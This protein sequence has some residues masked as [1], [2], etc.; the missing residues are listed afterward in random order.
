LL[1]LHPVLSRHHAASPDSTAVRRTRAV[2]LRASGAG[3][4]PRWGRSARF[5]PPGT[6]VW[7]GPRSG[8]QEENRTTLQT[9]RGARA[10]AR[11]VATVDAPTVSAPL[12]SAPERDRPD[13][14]STRYVQHPM[15]GRGGM[16]FLTLERLTGARPLRNCCARLR[17]AP[18]RERRPECPNECT[19]RLSRL[20]ACNSDR[21]FGP[22]CPVSVSSLVAS[23]SSFEKNTT[24]AVDH[25]QRRRC[26]VVCIPRH[27][28]S[29]A[30]DAHPPR[31]RAMTFPVTRLLAHGTLRAHR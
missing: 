20:C 29:H 21:T 24:G 5:V 10:A 15:I 17:S 3:R 9:I 6:V 27:R 23:G 26:V 16:G 2:P 28:R 25:S 4:K 11:M 13:P 30:S 12:Q 31:P 14:G 22:L 19:A 7:F 1:A 8:H 18:T